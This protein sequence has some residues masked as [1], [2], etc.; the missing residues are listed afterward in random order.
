MIYTW[1]CLDLGTIVLHQYHFTSAGW[2]LVLQ[3]I[4]RPALA[5]Q[6]AVAGM[7]V[8]TCVGLEASGGHQDTLCQQYQAPSPFSLLIW[9]DDGAHICSWSSYIQTVYN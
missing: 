1:G 4:A 5:L 7:T 8:C 9:I 2:V 3:A 6:V